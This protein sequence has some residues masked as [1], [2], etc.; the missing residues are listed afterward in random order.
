MTRRNALLLAAVVLLGVLPLWLAPAPAPGPDG[1][2]GESFGGA[3]AK[4]Q[5]AIVRIA[6][7]YRPW[8]APVLEPAGAEIAS[9]L[10]ALQAALGAGVLG[11]W[12]GSAVT[13]DRLRRE[14]GRNAAE[15][16]AAP[17]EPGAG[18]DGH[19]D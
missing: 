14:A 16:E 13:R 11:Y 17:A 19:A 18:E 1:R 7:D 12:L 8:F 15:G 4:A 10:F 2:P 3:D 9:L 6:P 5:Q